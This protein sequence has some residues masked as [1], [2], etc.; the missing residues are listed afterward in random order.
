M[1]ASSA[2]SRSDSQNR[3]DRPV[4]HAARGDEGRAGRRVGHTRPAERLE[5]GVVHDATIRDDPAL[6][7]DG[8]LTQT[9]VGDDRNVDPGVPN[10]PNGARYDAVFVPCCRPGVVLSR[11]YAEHDD[12]APAG[13]RDGGGDV[14]HRIDVMAPQARERFHITGERPIVSGEERLHEV[15]RVQSRFGETD[16]GGPKSTAAGGGA[17][18]EREFGSR[19]DLG[20]QRIQSGRDHAGVAVGGCD[21]NVGPAER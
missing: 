14:A 15:G 10:R 21:A 19:D 7:V 13:L 6:P 5:R 1:S 8:V 12:T 17:R 20:L 2:A 16:R 9:D 4:H 18:T 3:G 11:G